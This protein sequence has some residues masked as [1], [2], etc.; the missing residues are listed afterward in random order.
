MAFAAVYMVDSSRIYTFGGFDLSD[1]KRDFLQYDFATGLWTNV[2]LNQFNNVDPPALMGHTMTA[3]NHEIIVVGGTPED[4][5]APRHVYYFN[6]RKKLT[7]LCWKL[8]FLRK[9]QSSSELY[10]LN[11]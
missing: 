11:L 7:Q 10:Q 8:C 9:T 2:S 3:I 5:N 4:P 1:I 6:T